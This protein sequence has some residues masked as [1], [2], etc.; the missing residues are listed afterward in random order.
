[1]NSILVPLFGMNELSVNATH[2]AVRFGN[3]SSARLIF[4][5][6]SAELG[7]EKNEYTKEQRYMIKEKLER[8]IYSHVKKYDLKAEIYMCSNEYV[9]EVCKYV[10]AH[11]IKEIIIAIPEQKDDLYLITKEY[12]DLFIHMTNC[13]VITVKSRSKG[14]S[15][16]WKQMH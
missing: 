6:F 3:R 13:R 2:F 4:L 1:M 15:A 16:L 14:C 5:F 10:N 9:Y 12:I 8:L 11:N 7:G